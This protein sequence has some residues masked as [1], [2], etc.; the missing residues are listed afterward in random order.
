MPGRKPRRLAGFNGGAHQHDA[1][2]LFGVHGGDGH[3]H[4]EIGLAGAGGADAED[5]V[6]LLDGFDV[7][8]LI[9]RTRLHGAL[10]ARGALLAGI[11]KR[12]QRR[13]GIGHHQ[14]QHAIQFAVVGID[15]LPSERFEVLKNALDSGHRFV[16]P[17]HVH[18][19]GSKVDPDT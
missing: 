16:R 3:G 7:L 12:T 10:D 8:A 4:G 19:V 11:G 15:A 1:A 6:V 2:D 18:G 17:F 13:G 14:A 5:H 9:E